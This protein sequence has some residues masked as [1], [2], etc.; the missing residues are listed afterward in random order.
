MKF[1]T[2]QYNNENCL[3]VYEQNE[4]ILLSSLGYSFKDMNDLIEKMTDHQIKDCQKKL[5]NHE[6]KIINGEKK[7]ERIK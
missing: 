1:A 3:A 5:M 2:I 4:M 7:M 6:G